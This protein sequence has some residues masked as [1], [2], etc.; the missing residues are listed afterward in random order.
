MYFWRILLGFQLMGTTAHAVIALNII[1]GSTANWTAIDYPAARSDYLD[2]QQTGHIPSDLV[3]DIDGNQVAFYKTYDDGGGTATLNDD[4]I[5]FR[6]RLAAPDGQS[7]TPTWD[8]NLLVGIDVGS[9]RDMDIFLVTTQK[10][11]GYI[12]YYSVDN[13]NVVGQ[14]ISPATTSV[15]VLNPTGSAADVA[16][17]GG[18]TWER[19]PS[20]SYFD[21]SAVDSI[22]DHYIADGGVNATDNLDGLSR[23]N[24]DDTDFFL[25]FQVDM[26][27]LIEAVRLSTGDIL[28][29]STSL[30]FVLGTSIQDNAFNQDMNGQN[31]NSDPNDPYSGDPY[32]QNL[33]DFTWDELGAATESFTASG[34]EPVPEPAHYGI[35]LGLCALAYL[36]KRSRDV[37]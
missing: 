30:S 35:A 21:Y 33:K 16:D 8:S 10:S 1:G 12:R 22:T 27:T 3:G 13:P 5:G 34:V 36:A 37:E 26:L 17:G 28:D 18:F 32:S 2:D 23:S 20:S 14:N 7:G 11:G 24:K 29:G 9:D 4:W 6:A 19:S 15:S 31:G 25:S